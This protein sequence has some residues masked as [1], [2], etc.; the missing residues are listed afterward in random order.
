LWSWR[1][2]PIHGILFD[3]DGTL[4][5][6]PQVR[7]GVLGRLLRAYLTSPARGLRTLRLVRAYRAAQEQLRG[8]GAVHADLAAAHLETA[9]GGPPPDGAAALI[10][11]WMEL[12][13]LDLIAR[14]RFDGL[15]PF[16]EAARAAGLR[17]GAFSDYPPR[18]KIESLG[19]TGYLDTVVWAQDPQVG[20]FKPDPTGLAISAARMQLPPEQVVYVGDRADVDAPAAEAAGMPCFIL[21][22][23]QPAAHHSWTPVSGYAQLLALLQENSH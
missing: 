18:R 8:C 4:Y 9:C 13:P 14:A 12:E 7:R 6:L 22:T 20:R 10:E 1:N 5:R 2:Q 16:C 3:V 19:L 15:L 11:R 21:T 17:L 23:A